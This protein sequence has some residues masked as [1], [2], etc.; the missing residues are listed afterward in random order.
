[1]PKLFNK[2]SNYFIFRGNIESRY[3]TSCEGEG[4]SLGNAMLLTVNYSKVGD[5]VHHVQDQDTY[6]YQ[7]RLI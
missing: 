5:T 7:T 6:K 2:M 3:Y 1:M 4:I